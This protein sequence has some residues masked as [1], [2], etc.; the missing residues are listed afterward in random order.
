MSK[1]VG[2][3]ITQRDCCDIYFYDINCAFVGYKKNNKINVCN[4]M[5]QNPAKLKIGTLRGN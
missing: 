5:V 4:L 1:H 3:K 2:V